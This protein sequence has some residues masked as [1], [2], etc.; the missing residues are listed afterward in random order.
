MNLNLKLTFKTN[1]SFQSQITR[2]TRQNT[3]QIS[4]MSGTH[5][6]K[7][8]FFTQNPHSR[9]N[10]AK[11]KNPDSRSQNTRNLSPSRPNY[12]LSYELSA[13]HPVISDTTLGYWALFF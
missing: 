8:I 11:D 12:S 2:I 3:T 6:S 13:S 5:S 7:L 9:N 4:F 10:N 1:P